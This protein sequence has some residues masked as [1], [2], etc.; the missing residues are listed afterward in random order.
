[1]QL[2]AS[3]GLSPGAN[4]YNTLQPQ[5]P[6]YPYPLHCNLTWK[7]E[8]KMKRVTSPPHLFLPTQED[9]TVNYPLCETVHAR[10][11]VNCNGTVCLWLGANVMVRNIWLLF[12]CGQFIL[13]LPRIRTNRLRVVHVGGIHLRRSHRI[14]WEQSEQLQGE[15]GGDRR[16]HGPP[17]GPINNI[18]GRHG[19]CVQSQ[20][21]STASCK[22]GKGARGKVKEL[23]LV[24]ARGICQNYKF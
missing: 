19:A 4:H 24:D 22:R 5:S 15:I 7:V 9:M 6:T 11:A 17:Q 3:Y 23:I 13:Y 18:G 8:T 10:A 21:K 12:V 20:R 14:S 16:G 1:M 2:G